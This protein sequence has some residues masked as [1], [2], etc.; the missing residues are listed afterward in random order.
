MKSSLSILGLYQWDNTLFDPMIV[1]AGVDKQS[2]VNNILMDCAELEVLY[3]NPDTMKTAISI[4]SELSQ[5]SWHRMQDALTASYSP[6]E[7][8]DRYEDWEDG[9]TSEAESQVAAYNDST[10]ANADRA[11]SKGTGKHTGHLHGNIGVTTNQQM[12]T[13][14][15]EMRSKYNMVDIITGEFKRRFCLLVY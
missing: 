14:E 3:S 9:N 12:I 11:T 5:N 8:Y 4:W 2:V 6:I 13:E 1:P 7:N 10:M 15:M